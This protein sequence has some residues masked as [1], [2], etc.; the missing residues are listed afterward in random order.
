MAISGKTKLLIQEPPL[1]V[2][3]TLAR[4]FGVIGA[5]LLQ[6]VHFTAQRPKAYRR[7]GHS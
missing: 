2:L 4:R 5:M 6:Q 7:E 1:L 3:P